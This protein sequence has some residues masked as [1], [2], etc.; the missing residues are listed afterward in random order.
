MIS[1]IIPTYNRRDWVREAVLSVLEQRGAPAYELIVVDDGSEDDTA[2]VLA[3]LG[4]RLRIL[5]A[6]HRGVSAA[7][8]AGIRASQGRWVAFLDSDDLWLPDK[9]RLQME[10][11]T[12]SPEARICQTDE[13]WIRNGMRINR[14]RHHRLPLGH[15]FERLLERCLVSPSA[16]VLER[17]L[18]DEVGL[19][20]ESMPA[21]EDYDLWLRIGCRHAL[22]LI[23][24]PLV[25][26]RG[27][28]GDQLS[29]SVPG[30]DL[31]RIKA[32]EKILRS[33][34]LTEVQARQALSALGGRC[35]VYGR[36]CIKRGRVE[37]GLSMLGLPGEI[38]ARMG[39]TLDTGPGG[40][41]S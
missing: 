22:G 3:G 29:S 40:A 34:W 25:V 10:Y 35:A 5:S 23:P 16:V 2:S 9:L 19:F 15:C 39:L 13:V 41:S 12:S 30:L 6:P 26:K 21:C 31:W 27:G 8:N 38:A 4:D 24:R 36:G 20:D 28:H 18:L 1:V 17:S 33:G 14:K 37:E 7:R 11:L 32:I